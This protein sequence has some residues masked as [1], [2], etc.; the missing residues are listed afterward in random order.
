MDFF[1]CLL[2]VLANLQIEAYNVLLFQFSHTV[3]DMNIG[4]E[5]AG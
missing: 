3:N 1:L 5:K 2:L 4:Y